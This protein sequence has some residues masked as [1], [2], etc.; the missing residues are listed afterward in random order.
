MF[1]NDYST[2]ADPC[3]FFRAHLVSLSAFAAPLF[4]CLIRL[5]M[6]RLPSGHLREPQPA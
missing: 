6:I 1:T 3:Q 2:T 5:N 4:V